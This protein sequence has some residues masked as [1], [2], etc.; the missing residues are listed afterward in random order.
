MLQAEG[1]AYLDPVCLD[2]VYLDPDPVYCHLHFE[3]GTA[4]EEQASEGNHLS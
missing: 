2:L 1:L 3:F 4:Q